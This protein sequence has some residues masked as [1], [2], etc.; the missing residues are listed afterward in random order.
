MD[1][2]LDGSAGNADDNI[3]I[4]GIG[5]EDED[6]DAADLQ[7][8]FLAYMAAGT[9]T[10][11]GIIPSFHRPEVL[12]FI[13]R[14][15]ILDFFA[16]K[17]VTAAQEN[18]LYELPL[19]IDPLDPSDDPPGPLTI[20]ERQE[21]VAL[22]R[23]HVLRPLFDDH[24]KFPI[25]TM[26]DL[27]TG[28]WDVDTDG[29]GIVDSIWLDIGLP[30]SPGPDGRPRKPLVAILCRDLDGRLD[31]NVHSQFS[32]L[33]FEFDSAG[34]FNLNGYATISRG[35]GWG[36]DNFDDDGNGT[37][38]DMREA[39]WP[40]SDDRYELA[41]NTLTN[42]ASSSTTIRLPRGASAGPAEVNFAWMF[43][44]S[45]YFNL[46]TARYQ[47]DPTLSAWRN[48]Y[49]HRVGTRNGSVDSAS[50]VKH[51]GWPLNWETNP[52]SP[53]SNPLIDRLTTYG[54]GSWLDV[55]GETSIYLDRAG[56]PLNSIFNTTSGFPIR[57]QLTDSPYDLSIPRLGR[58]SSPKP[59]DQWGQTGFDDDGSGVTDDFSEAGWEGTNDLDS[60][61][62]FSLQEY[63]GMIRRV[64]AD[65]AKLPD[66]LIN[67]APLT[68]TDP[69]NGSKNRQLFT[70]VSSQIPTPSYFPPND[71]RT[72]PTL[73]AYF[74]NPGFDGM[75]GTGDDYPEP[76][77]LASLYRGSYFVAIQAVR[78][79]PCSSESCCPSK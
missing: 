12:N 60:D 53:P 76:P 48:G 29:D 37:V 14:Y 77:T 31:L 18:A 44:Q 4:P 50:F 71:L 3:Y 26:A 11:S 27:K 62:T 28:K 52:A 17:G 46:L 2:G 78:I 65:S 21:L 25:R 68:F 30:V 66:R 24:P 72:H 43:P 51:H 47:S 55:R 7:N 74:N 69:T 49:S 19:G 15:V 42:S 67:A 5:G 54:Y 59:L 56:L 73:A 22:K 40:G 10:S 35:A 1:A 13:H 9:S 16:S 45:E 34:R 61:S 70:T 38:D 20:P 58:R 36:V 6:Y 39:M 63:E 75:L 79:F 64:D 8:W 23:M 57:P 33:P 32:H 41:A